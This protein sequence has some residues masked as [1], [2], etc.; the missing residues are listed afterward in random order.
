MRTCKTCGGEVLLDGKAPTGQL[1]TAKEAMQA[2]DVTVEALR[3]ENKRLRE[4][5]R[6]IAFVSNDRDVD[7]SR[8][9]ANALAKEGP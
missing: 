8:M 5:L 3:G 4:V 7:F 2:I 1:V 6:V 9:A